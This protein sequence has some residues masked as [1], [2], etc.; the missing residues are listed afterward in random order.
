MPVA[1]FAPTLTA[2]WLGLAPIRVGRVPAGFG[3]PAAYVTVESDDGEPVLRCDVY[4]LDDPE[5]FAFQDV[6]VWKG[7]VAIG[8]GEVFHL[9]GLGGEPSVSVVLG[10]YFGHTYPSDEC[11]LVASRDHLYRFDADGSMKWRSA[12]LGLDGVVVDRVEGDAVEGQGE[13][14]PPGGWRPFKVSLA[15]GIEF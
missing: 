1:R 6:R 10:C 4:T 5:S 11:L 12:Q 7:R 2:E 14:D 15:S 13:W 8:F 3:T 9:I